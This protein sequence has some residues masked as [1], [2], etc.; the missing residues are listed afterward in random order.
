LW[1]LA[2][3]WI[4]LRRIPRHSFGDSASATLAALIG[5]AYRK[6]ETAILYLIDGESNAFLQIL[7]LNH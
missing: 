3:L 6:I 7:E 5:L 2:I 1:T 4:P